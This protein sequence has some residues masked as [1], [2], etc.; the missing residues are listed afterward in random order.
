MSVLSYLKLSIT[1]IFRSKATKDLGN[2]AMFW[3]G[4]FGQ[5]GSCIGAV[6]MFFVVNVWKVFD[7]STINA[8]N[9]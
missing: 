3:C 5:G 7:S 2:S 4:A 1:M 9:L 6:V 8:K